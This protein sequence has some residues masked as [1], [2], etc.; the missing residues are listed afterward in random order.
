MTEC[1][2]NPC[3][4]GLSSLMLLCSKYVSVVSSSDFSFPLPTNAISS[5]ESLLSGKIPS[6]IK[7]HFSSFFSLSLV[8]TVLL[9]EKMDTVC[10]VVALFDGLSVFCPISRLP[11][12]QSS[13]TKLYN[14][15][16]CSILVNSCFCSF[17]TISSSSFTNN[18]SPT[19]TSSQLF[20][21]FI[22]QLFPCNVS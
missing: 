14:W 19:V 6:S 18:R 20:F 7:S 3:V 2:V 8:I 9:S 13:R 1:S 21:I 4:D 22:L 11:F 17:M 16:L 15:S 12:E 5:V 10:N